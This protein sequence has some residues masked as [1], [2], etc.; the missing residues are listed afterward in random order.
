MRSFVVRGGIP[1]FVSNLEHKFLESI[2][3]ITYKSELTERQ[4]ELAKVLTSR[5]ILRRFL[6]V[7]KGIYYV[8][9]NDKGI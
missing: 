2:E 6:D 3:D 5:G 9:N 7:D 1:T 8:R 4:A